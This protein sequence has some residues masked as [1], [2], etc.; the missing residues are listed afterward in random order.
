[1]NRVQL[2]KTENCSHCGQVKQVLEKLAPEFPEMKVRE[3]PMATEEGMKLVQKHGIMAS[4]GIIING[5][6]AFQGGATE[7]QLRKA[8]K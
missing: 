5:E 1:M 2:V 6:L 3:I 7:E 4:P 8:L